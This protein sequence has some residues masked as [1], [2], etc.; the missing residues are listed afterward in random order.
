MSVWPGSLAS[1][2]PST[3]SRGEFGAV[4]VPRLLCLL[5]RHAIPATFCIPDHTALAYPD[6]VRRIAAEG[7]EITHHGWVHENPADF[8]EAGERANLERG[9][10]VLHKMAG[11][12]PTGYRSPAWDLPGISRNAPCGCWSS[13]ASAMI[14]A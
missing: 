9:L 14:R 8:D 12:R 2:N 10:E 5:E 13:S 1:R 4:A 3:I 6:L 11:I 7:H